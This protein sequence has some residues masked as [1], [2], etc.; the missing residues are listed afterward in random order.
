[1]TVLKVELLANHG[2]PISN[3]GKLYEAHFL[4]F[5]NHYFF[6]IVKTMSQIH[7]LIISIISTSI[8]SIS[9][10]SI[11]I[12]CLYHLNLYHLYLYHLGLFVVVFFLVQEQ[13]IITTAKFYNKNL[14]Q[15]GK[16]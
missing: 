10:I 11:C 7:I 4:F 1:M 15:R 8:I 6:T 5:S 2:S 12:I 9:V 14:T 16:F 3:D 13:V